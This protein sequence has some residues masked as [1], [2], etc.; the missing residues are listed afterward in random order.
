MKNLNLERP[1]NELTSE[2]LENIL[3]H[4]DYPQ[5]APLYIINNLRL[6]IGSKG[7]LTEDYF[8][9]IT[10]PELIFNLEDYIKRW[11]DKHNEIPPLELSDPLKETSEIIKKLVGELKTAIQNRESLKTIY[12]ITIRFKTEAGIPLEPIKYF[13]K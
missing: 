9:E 3:L 11:C 6:I 7:K 5:H 2:K 12:E 1:K 10:K 13:N 8:Y 4:G